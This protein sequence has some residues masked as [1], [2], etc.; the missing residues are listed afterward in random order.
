MIS[1]SDILIKFIGI[2]KLAIQKT[3]VKIKKI[4]GFGRF[5]SKTF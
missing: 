4:K 5:F 1:V 2:K 3:F